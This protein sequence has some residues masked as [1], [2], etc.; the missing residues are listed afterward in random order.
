[1]RLADPVW[2]W[3]LFAVPLIGL[4]V[5]W[6]LVRQRRRTM[7]FV[8]A[9][10]VAALARQMRWQRRIV[11]SILLVLATGAIA[12]AAARP[13]WDPQQETVPRLGRDVV[14]LVDVSRSMLAQ[15]LA[16]NR[17]ER[18]K[19]WISD[20]VSSLGS[21]RVAL[22]AFAGSAVVK[23]PLTIDHAFFKLSLEELNTDS[24]ARGGTLIGDAIRKVLDDVFDDENADETRT[25]DIILIT[26]GEDHE[27]FPV[28]A[29]KAAG[30]AGV[31][32]IAIGIGSADTG[33]TV[34]GVEYQN[35][36]VVSRLDVNTLTQIA[37]ATPG[38]AFL[39]VGTG[40]IDLEKVYADLV[41]SAEKHRVGVTAKT[42]YREGFQVLLALAALCL[43][44]EVFVHDRSRDP[45][46]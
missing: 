24:V 40:T 19:L 33:S 23:C 28:E 17:I 13:Q 15:D 8:G 9:E 27:S 7:A 43:A 18:S 31:R 14:F 30:D 38:G 26:D 11:R 21:D 3:S 1:M 36:A 12:V 45:M 10:H 25:R 20:L 44:M 35:R 32:V 2:L 46:G 5:A 4:L 34:P 16:P 42:V 6:M 41:T 22:V 29:A 39:N 37:A